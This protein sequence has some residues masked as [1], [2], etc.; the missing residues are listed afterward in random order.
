MNPEP[1]GLQSSRNIPTANPGPL[2]GSE[3][4]ENI[5]NAQYQDESKQMDKDENCRLRH[6]LN[7]HCLAESFQF[8][9]DEASTKLDTMNMYYSYIINTFVIPDHVSN[10]IRSS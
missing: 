3:S 1:S 7:T 9:N 6:G 10:N 2:R 8:L 4:F 5:P